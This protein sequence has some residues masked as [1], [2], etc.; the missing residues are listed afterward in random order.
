MDRNHGVDLR[1]ERVGKSFGPVRAVVDLDLEVARG[2]IVALI[3]PSGCGK[4]TTLRLVAGLE[5]PDTG[6][7]EIGGRDCTSVPPEDREVGFVFQDYA[8]FPHLDVASNIAFGLHRLPSAERQDRVREVL[9]T[10]GLESKAGHGPAQLSGG[11]QQR[12]A[13]AR[14]LAPRPRLLLLD[15]P[16]SNLDPQ[17]RRRVRHEVLAIIRSS[18]AA[19]LWVT[20]DHDEG[21]VVADRVAVMDTGEIRQ[22]GT[23]F[24]IWR[25]PADAWVAA[26]I[27]CGDLIPGRVEEGRVHTV[28]GE[29]EAADLPDGEHAQVLVH[30]EYVAIDPTGAPGIV[31]RRHFSGTDNVYCIEL[32]EGPLLHSRQP[33][34]VEMS[35][36][37]RVGLALKSRSLPV[38][39][40]RSK[41]GAEA[42]LSQR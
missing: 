31:V 19:A 17:L 13:L 1:L 7:I 9:A 36:G 41:K 14:A 24:E 6:V 29:I 38:F 34:E 21:L 18:G 15:E 3:G 26:F 28:L 40:E 39:R 27:G 10:V 2:E 42:A 23:P 11:Q 37:A 33:S 4:T 8:L 35:L 5:Q 25:H 32:D 12:V 22:M 20:H 16:F 30:P